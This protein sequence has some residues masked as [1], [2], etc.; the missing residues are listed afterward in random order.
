VNKENPLNCKGREE[1]SKI[2]ENTLNRKGGGTPA[3]RR[4]EVGWGGKREALRGSQQ[5]PLIGA[6]S[7]S[8]E[9]N[10]LGGTE[11]GGEKKTG[12]TGALTDQSR[13]DSTNK[14]EGRREE[15]LQIQP[16][17]KK[18]LRGKKDKN[19]PEIQAVVKCCGIGGEGIVGRKNFPKK[20][21]KGKTVGGN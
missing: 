21:P 10:E 12:R 9:E 14:N 11:E 1:K 8:R 3:R 20:K 7:K 5:K 13:K 4:T 17:R 16:K 18:R 2:Q 19:V 6:I 15:Y